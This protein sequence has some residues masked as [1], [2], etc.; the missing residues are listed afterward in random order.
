MTDLLTQR[1]A[2]ISGVAA[3]VIGALS[4]APDAAEAK[5]PLAGCDA[6]IANLR[7]IASD[8]QVDFAH[9]VIVTRAKS[10][11]DVFDVTT[12]AEVDGTLT[13]RGDEFERFEARVAEPATARA[14]TSFER[15]EN[16]ALRAALG[17]DLAKAAAK[18]GEMS[19][20]AR[21]YLA[22]SKERGDAYIAGKTEE[23]LPGA[24]GLG[25]IYTETDRALIIVGPSG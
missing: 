24:V 2:K 23:H 1:R 11:A 9:S 3:L 18:I 7:K 5:S 17:W 25:L 14:L 10:N 13:C 19:A 6:F 20:D 12:N 22:A 16:G 15:F 8:L 4:C 21:D